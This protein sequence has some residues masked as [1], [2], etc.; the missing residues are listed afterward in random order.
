MAYVSNLDKLTQAN[1]NDKGK[2]L[3]NIGVQLLTIDSITIQIMS[4]PKLSN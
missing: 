1:F 2:S 3:I 4:D